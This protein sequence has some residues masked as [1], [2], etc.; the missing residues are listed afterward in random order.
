MSAAPPTEIPQRGRLATGLSRLRPA[1]PGVVIAALLALL[2]F[3]TCVL[4]LAFGIPCPA[5]GL[6]RAAL[7]AARLDWAACVHWHPLAPAL[8]VA[9]AGTVAAAFVATDAGWRRIMSVVSGA[10]GVALIVVWAL[11]FV[12]VWGGPVPG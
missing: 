11:R 6:T 2:P 4:R 10:A 3:P 1:L 5:C 7:A 9:T 12:G 8:I